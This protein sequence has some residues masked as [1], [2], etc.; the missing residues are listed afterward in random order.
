[1]SNI[2]STHTVTVFDSAKSQAFNGQRLVKATYKSTTKDGKTIPPKYQGVCAS[3][4]VMQWNDVSEHIPALKEH[5]IE[6]VSKAQDGIFKALY[7]SRG[8]MMAQVQDSDLCM[9]S[10]IGFLDA[11]SS[12]GRLTKEFLEAWFN[13]DVLESAYVVFAEKLGFGSGSDSDSEL[14]PEQD[15]TILRHLNGYKDMFSALSGGRT[16]Y[17]PAQVKNLQKLLAL[18]PESDISVKLDKKLEAMLVTKPIAELLEL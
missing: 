10:V 4:P 18:I 17:T 16:I 3:I 8:G 9:E 2:S 13:S 5:I 12:G 15:A 6:L 1:M 11:E 14:T 7:E